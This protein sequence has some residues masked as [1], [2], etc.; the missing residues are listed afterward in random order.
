[1]AIKK[2][3]IILFI[4]SLFLS[5]L[6]PS[7]RSFGSGKDEGQEPENEMEFAYLQEGG[8]GPELWGKIH[9]DWGIC[10]NGA[11]QSPIDISNDSVEIV[12]GLEYLKMK[13]KPTVAAVKNRGHDIMLKWKGDAGS[14]NIDGTEYSLKQCHWHAPAEHTFNGTRPALEL[15]MVHQTSDG[16]TAVVGVTYKLGKPNKFLKKII[17][18]ITEVGAEEKDIGIV[19]PSDL[20]VGTNRYYRYLGS[21]T[22][23]PCTEGVIWTVIKQVK[24]VS[25]G[26]VKALHDAV[27]DDAKP[28]AR[29]TQA[30]KG[31]TV[32]LYT[33]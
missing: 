12:R 8:K 5:S 30:L 11:L 28:N 23:P 31:R 2:T 27:H 4:T 10:E 19:E 32:K 22:V 26:Q 33:P 13:Y 15:H 3:T 29:P 25:K 1:M 7:C 21:L 18:H 24:T 6:L 16:K 20:K 17:P 9:P 14:I